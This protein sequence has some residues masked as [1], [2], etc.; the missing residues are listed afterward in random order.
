MS[1][2]K[3]RIFVWGRL[4]RYFR[5]TPIY[6]YSLQSCDYEYNRDWELMMPILLRTMVLDD[7]YIYIAGPDEVSRQPGVRSAIT[8]ADTQKLML[9][10]DSLLNGQDG[11]KLLKVDRKTGK[12]ISGFEMEGMPAFDSM[13]SA[14]GNLY[15]SMLDGS[16]QCFGE[17]GKPLPVIATER[18]EEFNKS[19][20]VP[21]PAPKKKKKKKKKEKKK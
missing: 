4:R 20:V 6:Q 9:R 19:A 17:G 16:L 7:K 18:I 13:A 10:Q 15:L 2:D 11:S 12:I 14:Y 8:Q 21:A 3:E 1:F 5:W